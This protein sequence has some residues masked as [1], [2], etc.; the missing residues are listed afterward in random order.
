MFRI[1]QAAALGNAIVNTAEA[2]TNALDVKPFPVGLAL[3]AVAAAAGAAQIATIA[4]AKPGGGT[5]PSVSASTPTFGGQPVPGP[6]GVGGP[7]G[8]FGGG[9]EPSQRI[10]INIDGLPTSGMMQATV[11]RELMESINDQLG[12]GVTL[13]VDGGSGGGNAGT[14][15]GSS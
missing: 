2:I 6:V 4:S 13:D 8:G 11:V 1:N 5:T 15:R 9:G 7:G 3:A 10:D 12:D 14:Q